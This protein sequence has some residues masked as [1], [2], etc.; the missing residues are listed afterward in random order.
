MQAATLD[1]L[2]GSIFRTP[3]HNPDCMRHASADAVQAL[4]EHASLAGAAL[5]RLLLRSPR[6]AQYSGSVVARG[7]ALLSERLG[8]SAA[9][10]GAM[11][12]KHPLVLAASPARLD[13]LLAFLTAELGARCCSLPSRVG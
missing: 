8:V 9:Q 5:G 2:I 4:A 1:C 3:R 13:A 12:A 11:T 10:L 7:A 6:L